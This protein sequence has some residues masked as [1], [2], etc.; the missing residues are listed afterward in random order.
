[1][2]DQQNLDHYEPSKFKVSK[3]FF[4]MFYLFIKKN[5]KNLN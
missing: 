4:F 3:V 1:M 5:Q 2:K